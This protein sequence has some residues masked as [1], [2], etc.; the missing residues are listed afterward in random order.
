MQCRFRVRGPGESERLRQ[1]GVKD[2]GRVLELEDM[3]GGTVMFAASGVTDGEYLKG[4]QFHKGGAF[5]HSVV[6]R[7]ESSTI[8]R[9]HTSHRF[10]YRPDY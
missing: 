3:A 10:D 9:L 2:A 7:S 6:M 4:V 5:S 1:A 8:R